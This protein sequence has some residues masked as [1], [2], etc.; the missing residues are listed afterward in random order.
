MEEI[1]REIPGFEGYMASTLGRIKNSSTRKILAQNTSS[2]AHCKIKGKS[3]QK[4]WF[5]AITFP[6]I[7]GEH[8]PGAWVD[9]IDTDPTN[10]KPENLRWVDGQTGNMNNETTRKNLS[11]CKKGNKCRLGHHHT[12]ETKLKLSEVK[13]KKV[14]Q[15]TQSG[16]VVAVYLSTKDASRQTGVNQSNINQCCLNHPHYHTAGGFVWRF[17]S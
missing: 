8:F 9:H 5:I 15:L 10:D 1:W 4:A 16:E 6:E 3:I 13:G 12:S 2:R 7:C 14:E 17:I 11:A